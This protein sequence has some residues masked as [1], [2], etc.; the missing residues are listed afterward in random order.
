MTTYDA[1]YNFSI[2]IQPHISWDLRWSF[3]LLHTCFVLIVFGGLCGNMLFPKA[4]SEGSCPFAILCRIHVMLG[5]S[6][7]RSTLK[8]QFWW[9]DRGLYAMG[10]MFKPFVLNEDSGWVWQHCAMEGM[11]LGC[12]DWLRRGPAE[13]HTVSPFGTVPHS[14]I[15][16]HS[17]LGSYIS[18]SWNSI[19]L[20]LPAFA[21]HW[22]PLSSDPGLSNSEPA[23]IQCCSA[24]GGRT[25]SLPA[26]FE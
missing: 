8:K 10:H 1:N 21:W 9:T 12:S 6:R 26:R 18:R 13:D 24:F 3:P 19:L 16:C 17:G 25:C 14:V 7:K 20:S 11:L 2:D 23:D 15:V 5:S 4:P 22:H